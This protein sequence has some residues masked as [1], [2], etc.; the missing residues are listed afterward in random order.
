MLYG[1]KGLIAIEIKRTMTIRPRDLSGLR[2]F[3]HDYPMAR[4]FVFYGG[5]ERRYLDNMEVIPLEQA[6]PSLPEVLCPVDAGG[7]MIG[8]IAY[9][10]LKPPALRCHPFGI[11]KRLKSD[12]PSQ[13]RFLPASLA[14]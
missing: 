8:F 3:L 11:G 13:T 1:E 10:W 7:L 14:L 2:A 5:R 12:Y 6:L 4:A 9:R